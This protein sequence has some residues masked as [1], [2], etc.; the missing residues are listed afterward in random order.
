MKKLKIL[1]F[2]II[3]GV[4]CFGQIRTNDSLTIQE[5]NFFYKDSIDNIVSFGDYEPTGFV[6]FDDGSLII[7]T[8]F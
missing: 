3:T 6:S 8:E 5:F 2:C 4:S 7:S 1:I